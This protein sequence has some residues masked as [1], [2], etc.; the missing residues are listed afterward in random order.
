MKRKSWVARKRIQN[1]FSEGNSMRNK[2]IQIDNSTKSGKQFHDMNKKLNWD[3]NYKKE[4]N[5]NPIAEEFN[6]WENTIGSFNSKLDEA[7]EKSVIWNYLVREKK[8]SKNEKEWNEPTRFTGK[9]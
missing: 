6:G 8:S 1:N 4:P 9:H 5:R 2:K 3:R 7:E